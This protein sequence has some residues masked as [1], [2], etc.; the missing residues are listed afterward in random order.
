M[1]PFLCSVVLKVKPPFLGRLCSWTFSHRTVN[2]V[3]AIERGPFNLLSWI[4]V[5]F[6]LTIVVVLY[7]G[8]V[9]EARV[10]I[11]HQGRNELGGGQPRVH[12]I[13]S[14]D[15]SP[16]GHCDVLDQVTVEGKLELETDRLKG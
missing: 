3:P 7:E 13:S 1:S 14:V 12:V 15:E 11:R 6:P 5:S 16:S 9:R 8:V 2:A 4:Y 10:E